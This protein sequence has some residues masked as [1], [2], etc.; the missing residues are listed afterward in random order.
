MTP[1][2][3]VAQDPVLRALVEAIWYAY[4]KRPVPEPY[5]PL[6]TAVAACRKDGASDAALLRAAE[7][8]AVA[9]RKDGTPAQYV[10][11]AVRFYRDGVWQQHAVPRVEGR[12]REEWAR[13]GQDVAVFD[14]LVGAED[15]EML[16]FTTETPGD[17]HE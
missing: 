2:V 4:P 15:A 11:G 3:S 9:V 10:L 6:R 7:G 16:R 8:Y 14:A 12:T 17:W 13:S 5:V 1:R